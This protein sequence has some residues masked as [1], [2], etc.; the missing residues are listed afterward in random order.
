M[1]TASARSSSAAPRRSPRH[2]GQ[3]ALLALCLMLSYL[4]W[5]T[6]S[7]AQPQ[8]LDRIVAV[9]DE[10]V[11]L[12]SELSLRVRLELQ[13]EGRGLYMTPQELDQRMERT[14]EEMVNENVLV[15]KAQADSI[16]VDPAQVE[17]VLGSQLEQ[18]KTSMDP[19]EYTALLERSGLTERQLKSRYRKQIRHRLLHEQITAQIAYRQFINRRDIVAFREQY[20]DRLPSEVSISQISIKVKPAGDVVDAARGQ[21]EEIQ[22]ALERGDEFASVAREYSQDPGSAENGGDLGCFDT[23]LLVP[24]F[25]AA[26]MDLRPGQISE[27]VLTPFGYHLIL[28]HERREEELCCSHILVRARTQDADERR[29]VAQL[30]DLRQQAIDGGDFAQLA[31][32]HSENP[33]TARLG[34]L[35]Q[36]LPRDQIPPEL[37]PYI[38]HLGLGQISQPFVMEGHAHILKINDDQATLEGLVRQSRLGD[39]MQ[40]LIDEFKQEIH[41]E[42]R[43]EDKFLWDPLEASQAVGDTGS[44]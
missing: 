31:R 6:A 10:E 43:L 42:K 36:I 22:A 13:Q 18:I 23:Q 14:L 37:V 17:E 25:V 30:Q 16:E 3:T 4:A 35:W 15:L 7:A 21:I 12:W 2:G 26:A 28:L 38:G 19:T 9:I 24:E 34:G 41:V 32:D 44:S 27:P 39:Y 1:M 33:H 20:A 5:P 11:I 40:E 29:A 8:L